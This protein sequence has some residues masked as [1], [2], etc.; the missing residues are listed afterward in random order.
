VRINVYAEELPTLREL[1]ADPDR[2]LL[3]T[4]QLDGPDFPIFGIQFLIGP[5][6]EHTP[7]DD[8][9]S[10]VTFW[11]SDVHHKQSLAWMLKKALEKLE[12][13]PL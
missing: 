6:I 5:R 4:E 8:D 10:G 9:T 1:E 13:S 12:S 3:R 2:V 11:F 7:G